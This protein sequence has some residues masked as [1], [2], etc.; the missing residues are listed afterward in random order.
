[1]RL[2]NQIIDEFTRLSGGLHMSEG[3]FGL[4]Y[5]KC[6]KL[7]P[8]LRRGAG[9]RLNVLDRILQQAG[10]DLRAKPPENLR[11]IG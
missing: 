2:R 8:R 4:R 6:S 9:M 10:D 1:M 11:E 5:A 3:A 7:F